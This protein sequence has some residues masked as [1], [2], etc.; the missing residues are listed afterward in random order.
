MDHPVGAGHDALPPVRQPLLGELT[1]ENL[2]LGLKRRRQHPARTFPGN[3]GEGVFDGTWLTKRDDAGSFLH[4]VSF[5]L[6]VLA[7]LDH[8][9]RYAAF[10]IPIT[11]FRP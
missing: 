2:D 8:P 9:P 10:S 3:L 1:E 7:D 11:Q 5:L 4:G 6:E